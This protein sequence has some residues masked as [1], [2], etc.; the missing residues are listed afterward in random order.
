MN[1]RKF[2]RDLRAVADYHKLSVRAA[3]ERS[4]VDKGAMHRAMSGK[5]V[6]AG[7]LLAIC[8]AFQLDPMQYAA[9]TAT[10]KGLGK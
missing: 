4:G 6:T 10:A 9:G 5:P 8:A 7:T 1:H 3:A 2:A